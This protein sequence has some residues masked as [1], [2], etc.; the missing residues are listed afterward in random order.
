MG[1]KHTNSNLGTGVRAW[2]CSQP[3]A[4]PQAAQQHLAAAG[5]GPAGRLHL[6]RRGAAAGA[7][8]GL[9]VAVLRDPRLAALAPR[10]LLRARVAVGGG[11][12][13]AA[14]A[15]AR[16]GGWRGGGAA[17][18]GRSRGGLGGGRLLCWGARGCGGAGGRGGTIGGTRG[19]AGDE[20]G[21]GGAVK[22]L[23]LQA[24]RAGE[25]A[26]RQRGQVSATAWAAA[27]PGPPLQQ[28]RCSAAGAP[29]SLAHV[30]RCRPPP[31]LRPH[32]SAFSPCHRRG[33]RWRTAPRW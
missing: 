20:H 33:R 5:G 9:A 28:S 3:P 11:Q 1:R 29:A 19:G 10:L 21:V 30:C 22:G 18:A 17:A 4:S 6:W 31:S 23:H 26:H 7:A 2:Q 27:R 15:A 12:V 24:G 32:P 8:G 14:A 16:S 13:L 25:E